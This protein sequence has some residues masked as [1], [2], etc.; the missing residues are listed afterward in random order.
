[1]PWTERPF[2]ADLAVDPVPPSVRE[3]QDDEAYGNDFRTL[4]AVF[5][6]NIAER[7]RGKPEA[8]FAEMLGYVRSLML[9][10]WGASDAQF[11]QQAFADHGPTVIL[12]ALARAYDAPEHVLGELEGD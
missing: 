9:D 10:G 4:V 7:K 2:I 5:R 11:P 6:T 12:R 8:R 1:M 3:Q